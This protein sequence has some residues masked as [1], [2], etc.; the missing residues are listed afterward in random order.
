MLLELQYD[1][2]FTSEEVEANITTYYQGFNESMRL[3]PM[4]VP[5]MV[6]LDS[7]DQEI[8]ALA[9]LD[10]T[11][12]IACFVLALI[13]RSAQQKQAQAA[14]K[15]ALTIASYTIQVQGLPP[16]ATSQQVCPNTYDTADI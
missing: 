8:T 3:N 16:D 10:A 14:N 9:Y 11:I 2:G 5:S 13:A 1:L 7:K 15:E 6:A 12:C 4:K